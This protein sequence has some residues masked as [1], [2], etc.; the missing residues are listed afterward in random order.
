M[1][2]AANRTGA[3]GN[4]ADGQAAGEAVD[5]AGA[6]REISKAAVIL[7][8]RL[9]KTR[10]IAQA[11]VRDA[12]GRVMVCEL[13]YKRY[14]DLPGGVVD[15]HES[16][17]QALCRELAEELGVEARIRCLRVTSWLPPWRG[18]DDA[19]LFVFEVSLDREASDF[20]LQRKEIAGIHFIA[21]DEFDAHLAPYTARVLRQANR[22]AAAGV[23][24]VYLEDGQHPDW[25]DATGADVR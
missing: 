8:Q 16:P 3:S 6:E 21:D 1:A 24:G 9:P 12:S 2:D 22:A 19:M 23:A 7:N 11:L 18:W 4:R 25:S 15:P 13:T 20:V 14:W 5:R 10:I 17:A